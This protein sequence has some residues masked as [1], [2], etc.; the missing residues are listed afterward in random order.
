MRYNEKTLQFW[1]TFKH[2]FK[3]KGLSFFR[4]YKGQGLNKIDKELIRLI[5]VSTL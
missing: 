1:V 4:G 2:L 5:A 3:G